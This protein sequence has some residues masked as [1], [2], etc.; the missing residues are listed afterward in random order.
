MLKF[1]INKYLM[2]TLLAT[3][4]LFSCLISHGQ[5]IQKTKPEE[6]GI[7]SER[8]G[9]IDNLMNDLV[10][11]QQIP[12]ATVLI[13]RSGKT[14]LLK[15]YGY[16]DME[17]KTLLKENDIFRIASQTK[18]ITSLAVMM[19]FEEGKFL[20]DEPISKYIP[21]FKSPTV[22]VTFNEKDS[23]YT[24]EPAKSEIT[25]RQLLTH[26]SGID[27]AAIGSK[28]MRAIYAKAGVP[29]GIGTSNVILGDKMKILGKLP[30]R[31]QPGEK[32]LWAKYR[33]AGLP[34]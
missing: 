2:K 24:T 12:G 33:C 23:S 6:V 19:L 10:T 30:L 11:R 13:V 25:I 7:S 28:E 27:Y 15:S 22:L 18:A 17:K 9:R 16:S 31:H 32:Y 3:L 26:T 34:C 5:L 8:L 20:L 1:L 29:S 21:E 14:A 4:F